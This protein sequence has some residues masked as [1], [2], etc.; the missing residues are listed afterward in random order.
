MTKLASV[1]TLSPQREVSEV[2]EVLVILATPFEDEVDDLEAW[3]E[4]LRVCG[5][6]ARALNLLGSMPPVAF[7]DPVTGV[8]VRVVID[9]VRLCDCDGVNSEVEGLEES[10]AGAVLLAEARRVVREVG[11]DEALVARWN[12][13]RRACPLV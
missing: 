12:A 3:D 10:P 8:E 11:V 13:W 9:E 4:H 5:V 7:R 6:E 2:E 1:T